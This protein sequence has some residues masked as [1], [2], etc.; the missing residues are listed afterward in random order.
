MISGGDVL[1]EGGYGGHVAK[2]DGQRFFAGE[3]ASSIFI[4]SVNFLAVVN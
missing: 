4:R 1:G 3:N 2:A